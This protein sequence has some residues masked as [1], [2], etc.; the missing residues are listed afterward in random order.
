MSTSLRPLGRIVH[1]QIQRA[2]LKVGEKPNR[3]YDPAPILAVTELTLTPQGALVHQADGATLTD[4]HHAAHPQTRNSENVNALSLGF[5]AH[6]SEM[7]ARFGEHL[8]LGCAGENIL[9][10]TPGHVTLDDV[11][12]GVV[13]RTAA[14]AQIELTRLRV[15]APCRPFA[16]YALGRRVE[17]EVLKDAL[18][19]LDAG[20]RGFY[21]GLAQSEPATI[22]VGDEVLAKGS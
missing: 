18:Q 20:T 5:T 11:A 15:A 1:L 17:A 7:R 10:E 3:V 16:G 4:V 8:A 22:A 6:Y 9:V 21:C 2:P 14:G 12:G 19:F 13:I